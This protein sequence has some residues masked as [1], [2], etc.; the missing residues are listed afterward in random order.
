M[1][2][3]YDF[4]KGERGKFYNPDARLRIPIYLDDEVRGFLE[5]HANE[6]GIDLSEAANQ[7][8][9]KGMERG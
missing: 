7:I 3:D 9:R 1:K 2:D 6:K 5:K 4:V 8:L